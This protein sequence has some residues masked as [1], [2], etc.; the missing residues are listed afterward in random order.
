MKKLLAYTINVMAL[1]SIDAFGSVK[2]VSSA[3]KVIDQNGVAS[4]II[5]VTCASKKQK[6]LI[7][8]IEGDSKWCS[9]DFDLTCQRDKAQIANK[10]CSLKGAAI[11]KSKQNKI[12]TAEKRKSNQQREIELKAQLLSIQER[13]L[14]IRERLLELNKKEDALKNSID[15]DL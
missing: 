11:A 4:I 8:K 3:S 7:R 6:F 13:R 9:G 2:S 14:D 15:Q 1:L 10:V 5:S 12:K